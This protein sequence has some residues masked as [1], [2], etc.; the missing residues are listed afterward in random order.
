MHYVMFRKVDESFSVA[1]L[2]LLSD[3]CC[4]LSNKEL[5]LKWITVIY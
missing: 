2:P 4:S 3:Q 5:K 1:I